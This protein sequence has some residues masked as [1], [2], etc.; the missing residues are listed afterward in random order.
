M[1]FIPKILSKPPKTKNFV[2][3]EIGLGRVNIAIFEQSEKNSENNLE[4]SKTE[5]KFVGVGRRSF[6]T[7]DTIL[8]ATLEATDAL[9]AIVDELPHPG[10][11]GVSGGQL[12]AG[13]TVA[14]YEREDPK[15]PIN[16]EELSGVLEKV[17]LK[18][19][20]GY[21]VFF[22]AITGGRIDGNK[23]TNP[24]GVKGKSAEI[25]CFVAYKPSEELAAYDKIIEELELKPVKIMPTAF[26]VAQMLI[27]KETSSYLLLRV[28][29]NKTEASQV[30]EGHLVRVSNFDVG[31]EQLEFL[32]LGIEVVLEKQEEKERCQGIWLYSDSEEVD[33]GE[34][35][36]EINKVDW[37]KK[38]KLDNFEIKEEVGMDKF[39]PSDSG[40][41]ALS[42]Q[43]RSQL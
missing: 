26:A 35:K 31:A 19:K 20:D 4:Q 6:G 40:I 3:L 16:Q 21:K 32:N 1:K 15:S 14:K 24:V 38:F 36:K 12:E 18:E 7:A 9:G 29:V 34:V 2:V 41:L 43:E 33:L 39:G 13:T 28:G 17:A 37:K 10:L 11:V 30:H 42:E 27:T 5:K 25:N 8:D 22:S 23:V